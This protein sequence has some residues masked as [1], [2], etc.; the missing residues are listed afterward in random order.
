MIEYRLGDILESDCRCIC[1]QVNCKAVMGAGLAK[2]VRTKYPKVYDEYVHFCKTASR[3]DM[4]GT[5]QFV[6][7]SEHP[8]QFIC[9]VFGQYA[10]G[11]DKRYT[12]YDALRTAF[13]SVAY[14]FPGHSIAIPYKMGCGL[15]GG[16]WDTVLSIIED[17]LKDC[18][19]YIYKRGV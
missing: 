9:N 13:Q 15:G 11:T 19:V 12:D 7:V 5:A 8:R 6:Q 4:L 14:H 2:Q 18:K 10:F 1:H 3:R 17:E 16:D